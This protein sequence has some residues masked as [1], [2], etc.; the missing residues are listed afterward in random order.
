M[1]C[2]EWVDRFWLCRPILDFPASMTHWFYFKGL[3]QLPNGSTQPTFPSPISFPR[4]FTDFGS[5]ERSDRVRRLSTT[6]CSLPHCYTVPSHSIPKHASASCLFLL[7]GTSIFLFFSLSFYLLY[8]NISI[9]HDYIC[10][11]ILSCRWI[12]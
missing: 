7:H 3:D 11:H 12:I 2:D 8:I 1:L 5:S 6:C 9:L 10:I 4:P